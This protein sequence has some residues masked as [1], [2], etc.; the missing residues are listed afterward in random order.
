MIR[1]REIVVLFH[2]GNDNFDSI[3]FANF[4]IDSDSFSADLDAFG[5]QPNKVS[6]ASIITVSF[7]AFILKMERQ[8]GLAG[9]P[10]Y[11]N[12]II[13]RTES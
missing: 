3:K 9:L 6:A 12:K 2:I 1:F 4:T 7:N 13:L 8:T 5:P 11:V 10:D